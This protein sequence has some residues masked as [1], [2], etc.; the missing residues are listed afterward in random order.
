[1]AR[2]SVMQSPYGCCAH[3]RPRRQC[4][5]ISR[6]WPKKVRHYSEPSL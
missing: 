4:I 1:M 3:T 5:I 2:F 6:G